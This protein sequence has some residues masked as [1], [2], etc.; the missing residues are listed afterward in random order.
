MT[1]LSRAAPAL[2][3][4]TLTLT[5]THTNTQVHIHAFGGSGTPSLEAAA[6]VCA[7]ECA[8]GCA[9]WRLAE[10]GFSDPDMVRQ[11]GWRTGIA[12]GVAVAWSATIC[13]LPADVRYWKLMVVG[14]QVRQ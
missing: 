14:A 3:V 5:H 10:S 1:Y 13:K 7:L 6:L 2:P 4:P 11:G 12:L 8:V 9:V